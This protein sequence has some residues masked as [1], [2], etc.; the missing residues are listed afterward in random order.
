MEA[1]M[2]LIEK[3]NSFLERVGLTSKVLS[4]DLND[5]KINLLEMRLARAK[6]KKDL[7]RIKELEAELETL[8]Q[9]KAA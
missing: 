7:V 5:V 9:K 1:V 2:L 6:E 8:K 4:E 3:V